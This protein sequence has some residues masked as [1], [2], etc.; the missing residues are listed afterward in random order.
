M[1][2]SCLLCTDC[3]RVK[4]VMRYRSKRR[5]V[6][7]GLGFEPV[8]HANT[9]NVYTCDEEGVSQV[10]DLN[11]EGASYTSPSF[12]LMC[13]SRASAAAA[14]RHLTT[15][16]HATCQHRLSLLPDSSSSSPSG[17][18]LFSPI[19][20]HFRGFS[21][22]N[23][24]FEVYLQQKSETLLRLVGLACHPSVIRYL[25]L[26]SGSQNWEQNQEKSDVSV[27]GSSPAHFIPPL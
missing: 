20:S 14:D 27:C 10:T 18:R 7:P 6:I 8:A 22:M 2:G 19:A 15:D 17:P 21:G 13:L 23:N 3:C 11:Q 24:S 25:I 16:C 5:N 1:S 9:D 26:E 4:G 12:L